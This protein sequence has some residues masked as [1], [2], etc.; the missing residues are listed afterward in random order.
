MS[1][2]WLTQLPRQQ[3][4]KLLSHAVVHVRTFDVCLLGIYPII[5]LVVYFISL[6]SWYFILIPTAWYSSWL[7]LINLVNTSKHP[8]TASSFLSNT[9]T[10]YTFCY[11]AVLITFN[12]KCFLFSGLSFPTQRMSQRNLWSHMGVL[13]SWRKSEAIIP[14]N[15]HVPAAEKYGVWP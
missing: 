3:G 5:I 14:R 4:T 7:Q 11:S 9:V 8:T 10:P 12:H 6:F 15:P 1:G 2:V 13:E